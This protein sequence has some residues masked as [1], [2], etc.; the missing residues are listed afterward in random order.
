MDTIDLRSDAM[1]AAAAAA[2]VSDDVYGEEPTV[3]A[4]QDYAAKLLER[5]VGLR[6]MR[7]RLI[8]DHHT[9]QLP[10]GGSAQLESV[11]VEPVQVE[12]VHVHTNMVFFRSPPSADS[13]AL[14][15]E[16]K[17]RNAILRGSSP[18]GLVTNYCI[19]PERARHALSATREAL[20]LLRAAT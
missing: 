10:A 6:H 12:S 11:Q 19:T 2:P 20:A 3:H 14:V 17:G 9:A 7:E 4:L 8:E 16:L 5:E 1:R 13:A 18:F 15:A